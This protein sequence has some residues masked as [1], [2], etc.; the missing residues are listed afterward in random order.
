MKIYF[1]AD[2][3]GFPLKQTLIPFV[4]KLGFAVEDKGAFEQNEK[5]DY[6]DFIKKAASEVSSNPQNSLAIVI[7]GSGEGEAI[8]ANKYP[9]VRAT[10]YY[11]GNKEIIKLS[12]E[13]NDANVLSLGA[14]FMSDAEAKAV[15]KSW[16]T[17]HF[18]LD[19]RHKRRIEKIEEIERN[20]H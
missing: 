11:G 15:V 9:H 6:P 19:P 8:V 3:A 4:E 16:L 14:R 7:G 13:H 2:H 17:S 18:S 12:H 20:V 1:A 10:V 5:D